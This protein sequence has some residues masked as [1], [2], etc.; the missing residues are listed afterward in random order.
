MMTGWEMRQNIV[1]VRISPDATVQD[2][3]NRVV[4][5]NATPYAARNA[6]TLAVDGKELGMEKSLK[7][8]GITATASPVVIDAIEVTDHLAHTEAVRPKD[9]NYDELTPA[10]ELQWPYTHL[11]SATKSPAKGQRA[12]VMPFKPKP[13][14]NYGSVF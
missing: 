10:D 2:L 9:W 8:C 13:R 3:I 1:A 14:R 4:L 12:P 7:E 6:F 5:D 11:I